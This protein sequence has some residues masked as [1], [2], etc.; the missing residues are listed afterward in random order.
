MGQRLE[1]KVAI[2]T[3]AGTGIGAAT[4]KLF[5]RE[6]ATVAMCGRRIEP[7]QAVAKDIADAGGK[8]EY[9]SVDVSDDVLFTTFIKSTREKYG[10]LNIL[11]NNAAEMVFGMLES[12]STEDWHAAF[13]TSATQ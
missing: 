1:R 11:V 4:A 9:Q 12:L 8:A 13:R 5:A 2:I 7:L 10:A 6:G 3:G